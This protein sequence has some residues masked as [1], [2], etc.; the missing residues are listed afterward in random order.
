VQTVRYGWR[1]LYGTRACE[2]AALQAAILQRRGWDGDAQAVLA[3]V[4]G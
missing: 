2:T 4:P 1:D 3:G